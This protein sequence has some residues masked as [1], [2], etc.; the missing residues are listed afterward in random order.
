MTDIQTTPA[1]IAATPTTPAHA[2]KVED[3]AKVAAKHAKDAKVGTIAAAILALIPATS[4]DTVVV[5][6]DDGSVDM[7]ESR[8][9][10]GIAVR[11]HLKASGVLVGPP[12]R[13]TK[14][15]FSNLEKAIAYTFTQL[16]KDKPATELPSLT[17]MLYATCASLQVPFA[18]MDKAKDQ[19]RKTMDQTSS[20]FH[21]VKG[22]S[23]WAGDKVGLKDGQTITLAPFASWAQMHEAPAAAPAATPAASNGAADVAGH[24]APAAP[25]K[26]KR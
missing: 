6:R 1:P 4:W 17:E 16:T 26:R 3:P 19:V 23:R 9:A 12:R 5:K 13:T 18:D 10:F 8:R 25:S 14:V 20:Q 21:L 7:D 24:T 2:G 15:D 22:P 11:D